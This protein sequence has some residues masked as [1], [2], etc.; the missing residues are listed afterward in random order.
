MQRP[1]WN[2]VYA[3]VLVC[4]MPI[5]GRAGDRADITPT[6]PTKTGDVVVDI[7]LNPGNGLIKS[8]IQNIPANIPATEKAFLMYV[9]I[10]S[11]VD[12][13][14]LNGGNM[15]V[16]LSGATVTIIDI[17]AGRRMTVKIIGDTTGEGNSLQITINET[18]WL[19]KLFFWSLQWAEAID[20]L[21]V[22]LGTQAFIAFDSPTGFQTRMVTA[23]GVKT[24]GQLMNE[25][26]AS[27]S[28]AGWTFTTVHVVDPVNGDRIELV[29][30]SVSASI[31]TQTPGAF[32]VMTSPGWSDWF[33]NAGAGTKNAPAGTQFCFGDGSSG[34][35]PC[36]NFGLPGHGCNNSANT[37]GATLAASGSTTPDTIVLEVSGELASALSIFLQGDVSQQAPFGDGVRCAGGH[38]VRLASKHASGGYTFYPDQG[39]PGIRQRAAQLGD[40]IPPGAMRFYQVYY[41]DPSLSFCPAPQG[42]SWNIS[43]AVALQWN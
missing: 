41:R 5:A 27:M 20:T 35:C 29:S 14:P 26:A 18:S 12:N 30:Q 19:D 39:D 2:L 17:K 28:S 3:L 21:V 34:P 31:P 43:D 11:D 1:G 4:L 13:S 16:T 7:L 10:K 37:G 8:T 22:P 40:T 42:N 24:V 23:D 25:L 38:L 36:G 33:G 15:A 9:Q 6:V 32:Q